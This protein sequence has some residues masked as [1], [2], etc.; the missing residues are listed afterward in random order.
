MRTVLVVDDK[1][2]MR[3]S[4]AATLGRAGMK[5]I[6]ATDGESALASI[7]ER[8]PD[9]VVTDLK[10][11]GLSGLELIERIRQFDDELPIVLMTAFGTVET[12]V[13][14]M[15]N[16]AFDYVT[17]PFEGDELIISVKRA[18]QHASV[19][20]ENALL[21]AGAS[22]TSSPSTEAC[23]IR[24]LD[25]IVGNSPAIRRVKEQIKAVADSQSNVLIVGESGT[26]KEVVAQAIH[27][28]SSRAENPFLAVN[29]AALSESLLESELFGHE[30]GAFTGADKMRKGRF[31]LANTG[32]LL[33]D[34]VSEVSLSIQAKLLRVLQERMFERVGSS[35]TI[36]VDVRVLAT[37]NRD[38]PKSVQAGQF[39]QDLFFRLNV[40][41][42]HLP[43][44]RDR[45][46]DVPAL[47][48]T[49]ITRICAREGREPIAIEPEAMELMSSYQWPGNVRELQNICERAV[50]LS[51]GTGATVITRT[52]IEPWLGAIENADQDPLDT[53]VGGL[54]NAILT[55]GR[56]ASQVEPK[57]NGS[58]APIGQSAASSIG[59]SMSDYGHEPMQAP[60]LMIPPNTTLEEMEREAIVQTLRRFNGHRAKTAEALDIGVRTL[61]LKL[62]KW[63]EEQLVPASL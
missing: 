44:L 16:G 36:G 13:E 39:R 46:E 12:A 17:K 34:E 63:K 20:R 23:G 35:T 27:D 61:G 32:T 43:P 21:R 9:A 52:L 29:C 10:M 53:I 3:D 6:T 18:I 4:V 37:S 15:R 11:P 5:V 54:G 22:A 55:G 48:E 49:F 14:A 45:L 30:K 50:V 24:G 60:R 57:P 25:R 51:N 2:M 19:L 58:H 26:G 59:H 31:E 33:L 42:I 1:E 40:V 41:P 7:A 62:K 28:L 8:R 38:L 47:V 56:Y